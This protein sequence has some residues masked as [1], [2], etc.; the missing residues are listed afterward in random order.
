MSNDLP[1][2]RMQFDLACKLADYHLARLTDAACLWEPGPGSWTV[3]RG[4]DGIWRPDWSDVEPDPA[5]PVT[6]GWLS[7]HLFWWWRGAIA[8]VREAP[9]V[10]RG[11]VVWPGSADSVRTEFAKISNDW[12]ALLSSLSDDD[13]AR[14]LTFLW[15]EP[16]PLWNTLAWVNMELMKNVA[17]IG[18]VRHLHEARKAGD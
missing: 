15:P 7:W 17:E 12:R 1:I 10:R 18:I 14:P 11:D 2:L 16:R 6:I 5:P 9:R 4:A 8:A 13:L 3:R